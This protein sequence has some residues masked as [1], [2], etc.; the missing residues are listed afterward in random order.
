MEASLLQLFYKWVQQ[1]YTTLH[2]S[3]ATSCH[4]VIVRKRQGIFLLNYY[5][6]PMKTCNTKKEQIWVQSLHSLH[7]RSMQVLTCIAAQLLK[8]KWSIV[9]DVFWAHAATVH[10]LKKRS[11]PCNSESSN[12]KKICMPH[13][14]PTPSSQNYDDSV[15]KFM[16]DSD[17]FHLSIDFLGI[18][19]SVQGT[20]LLSLSLQS[21]LC[22]SSTLMPTG[23]AVPSISRYQ[24]Q[25]ILCESCP[26]PH[27]FLGQA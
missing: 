22:P 23:V 6:I 20:P 11:Q 12:P 7:H 27:R 21:F 9:E 25:F 4:R 26:L 17:L 13:T 5:N 19:F 2:T 16:V 15:T 1:C 24:N 8:E 14:P 3:I 18:A 10:R